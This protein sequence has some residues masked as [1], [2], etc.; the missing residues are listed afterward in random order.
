[1]YDFEYFLLLLLNGWMAESKHILALNS[2]WVSIWK[3]NGMCIHWIRV[4]ES[5]ANE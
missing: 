3:E 1:M 2:N 4:I 5:Q